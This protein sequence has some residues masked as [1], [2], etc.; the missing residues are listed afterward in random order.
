MVHIGSLIKQELERQE[1]TPAWLARK[2]SCQR[3]NMYYIFSQAHIN[4]ELLL[5]ISRALHCDFF[6]YYTDE[7]HSESASNED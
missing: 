5:R 2:I 4:T 1:R 6:A 3:P 7:L